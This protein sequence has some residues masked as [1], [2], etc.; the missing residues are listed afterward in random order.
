MWICGGWIPESSWVI[1]RI[2]LWRAG[3]QSRG[4]GPRR[5]TCLQQRRQASYKVKCLLFSTEVKCVCAAWHSSCGS[6]RVRAG[7]RLMQAVCFLTWSNYATYATHVE[8][9]L[10]VSLIFIAGQRAKITSLTEYRIDCSW[11]FLNVAVQLIGK[12]SRVIYIYKTTSPSV[13]L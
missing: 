13:A 3:K 9:D 12:H 11:T 7:A 4:N 10:A 1:P 8:A 2:W 6:R 5:E